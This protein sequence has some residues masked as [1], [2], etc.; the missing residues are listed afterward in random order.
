MSGSPV[1]GPAGRGRTSGTMHWWA[2]MNAFASPSAAACLDK[3]PGIKPIRPEYLASVLRDLADDDALFFA[4][5]G[6][7]VIWAARHIRYGPR[8]RL[9]GSFSWASMATASPC[10]FGA[11]LTFPGRETIALCGDGGFTMLA[12]G[13]LLTEVQRQLPVVHIVLLA[14]GHPVPA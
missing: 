14:D 10:A 9:L 7:P 2:A 5:T 8:R 1:L 13:D 11:Q 3:G 12:L 4:D 6:T